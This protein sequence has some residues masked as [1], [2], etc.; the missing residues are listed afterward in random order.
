MTIKVRL[1]DI[2]IDYKHGDR[3]LNL[4]CYL[5]KTGNPFRAESGLDFFNVKIPSSILPVSNYDTFLSALV[6]EAVDKKY[7]KTLQG[8]AA[9]N[10]PSLAIENAGSL[11]NGLSV[12]GPGISASTTVL[13]VLSDDEIK[14]SANA[15]LQFTGTLTSSAIVKAANTTL[16]SFNISALD[17]TTNLAVGMSV[18]GNGI[19]AGAVVTTILSATTIRISQ[20][21]G[22]TQ[23]GVSLTF[24]PHPDSSLVKSVTPAVLTDRF[25]GMFISGSGI[26]SGTTITAVLANNE[27]EISNPATLTGSSTLSISGASSYSFSTS[28]W[29]LNLD[30]ITNLVTFIDFSLL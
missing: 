19:P 28:A 10:S 16:D 18:S 17:T 1:K 4:V 24:S 3:T 23:T 20:P 25:V 22:L 29:T 7:S 5:E 13:A 30:E 26:P 9:H 27:I 12:T 11:K 21:A 14:L 8:N 2:S 15:A 6:Q